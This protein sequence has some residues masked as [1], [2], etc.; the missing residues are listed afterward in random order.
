[1]RLLKYVSIIAIA[2]LVACDVT[3]STVLV[4]YEQGV[5]RDLMRF[6]LHY[7]LCQNACI[8]L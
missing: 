8:H 1:M 4:D 6:V 5:M 2:V 3:G 7:R